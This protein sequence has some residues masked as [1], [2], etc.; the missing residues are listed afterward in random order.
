[1]D[2]YSIIATETTDDW[3]MYKFSLKENIKFVHC[4]KYKR[5]HKKTLSW[6]KEMWWKNKDLVVSQTT[7]LVHVKLL[8]FIKYSTNKSIS[9]IKLCKQFFIWISK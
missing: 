3:L 9:K 8:H 1:M 6:G 7:T 4:C 5:D 2:K